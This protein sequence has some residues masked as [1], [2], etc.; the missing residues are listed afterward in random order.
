M[1]KLCELFMMY[2]LHAWRQ[3]RRLRMGRPPEHS[4]SAKFDVTSLGPFRKETPLRGLQIFAS[5]FCGSKD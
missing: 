3:Q 4:G 1:R 2:W 5:E